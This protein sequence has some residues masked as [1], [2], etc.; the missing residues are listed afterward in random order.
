MNRKSKDI[1]RL[2]TIKAYCHSCGKMLMESNPMT[3]REMLVNWDDAVFKALNIECKDCGNKFPNFNLDLKIH[4]KRRKTDY[5]I[6]AF[7][8]KPKEA[9]EELM[10][11]FQ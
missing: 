5:P 1:Q 6:E 2:F 8:P 10:K 4:D 9:V 3:R 7:I 11:K